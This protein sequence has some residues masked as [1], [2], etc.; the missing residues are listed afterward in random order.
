VSSVRPASDFELRSLHIV[1][2]GSIPRSELLQVLP[3]P[4]TVQESCCKGQ[5]R[6]D[7]TVVE[8]EHASK[9]L[10]APDRLA[11]PTGLGR[12]FQE[13]ITES[14]VIPLTMVM[15]CVFRQRPFKRAPAEWSCPYPTGQAAGC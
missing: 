13:T 8:T 1:S 6:G 11:E 14:L 2:S 3:L 10:A 5:L 9:P 15:H 12:I 7:R 4:R